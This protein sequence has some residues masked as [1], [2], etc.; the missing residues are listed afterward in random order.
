M[1]NRILLL[2]NIGQF[3]SVSSAAKIP[4]APL[5]LVYSE[6]GRGKT[7]LAAILRSLATG[8]ALPIAERRRLA[9]QN[10][11][12]VV[13]E[14][15]GGPPPAVFEN[16]AWNRT[17]ADLAVFDDVFVDHN[18]CSGLAVETHHG[19]NLHEMVLGATAVGLNKKLLECVN[20]I[21]GHN[22][23]LRDKAGAI[24][25]A[26][27]G[28]F[29]V[30]DFCALPAR[31]DIDQA[32]QEAERALAAA[33]EQHA[34]R[35]TSPF[36]LLNL[37]EFDLIAI[38]RVL[39]QDLPALEVATL[40]QVQEHLSRLG[41]GGEE[42]VADGVQRMS[43][44]QAGTVAIACPFCAQDLKGSPVIQH[45]REYFSHEYAALKRTVSETLG[46]VNREHGEDMAP[47]FERA[48][49]VAIERRQFWSRFCE[50]AEFA[51]D[52][53][54]I[55]RDWRSAREAVVAQLTA[56]QAAP[57]ECMVLSGNTQALV[58]AYEAHRKTVTAVN[59]H[60]LE[61]NQAIGVA[62]E[63]AAAADL[64]VLS[65]DIVRLKAMKARHVPET[66][67]LCDDYLREREAKV[68]TE[69]E[70]EKAKVALEQHRAAVFPG[71]QAAINL[72]LAKFNAGFRLD[73]MWYAD[74]RGGPTCRYNALINNTPVAIGPADPA[75][76]E[77]AFRNTLSSGDR[78][79]LALAFFFASLDQDASL[80]SKVV[81]ID[82][83]ICSL[84]NNR[85]WA[86]VQE[87]RR[88][89][90]RTAQVIVLS[91]N[92]PFLCRL[93]EWADSKRRAALEMVRED[94]G[95]T[96]REWN[97]AEDYITEHDRRHAMLRSYSAEGKGDMRE[98]A[99]SIRPHLEAFLRVACPGQFEPECR[100]GNF[101]DRCEQRVGTAQQIFD[102]LSIR[103]LKDLNEYASRYHHQ[104]SETEP[105]N[106]GELRGFVG[107]ALSFCRK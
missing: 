10:P 73:S 20:R 93:S 94:A 22:H 35:T 96:L 34:I 76:G 57:L 64:A 75:S 30:D 83:P 106:D 91:H 79:T 54:V 6:N 1:I 3:D 72:Y 40:K 102:G 44:W 65:D 99:R 90:E 26:D 7:T 105:I 4:L 8:N 78:H 70:R 46:A 84:D 2:R 37:P 51:V 38:E 92:K 15:G 85:T 18:V 21:E 77:P 88:L 101:I 52:T 98:V 28:P 25:T 23:N 39:Q 97:I 48:V 69:A 33:K 55:V 9:A 59:R 5:T 81:V 49:R 11:P 47:G 12:H 43:Q 42:W 29:P 67:A 104:G 95:S 27:R 41:R 61:A 19:Q 13:I 56:K 24:P 89:A 62:K 71:Y 63:R 53:A 66:S 16:G 31:L 58:T 17:L 100:L 86:T 74:T 60:L 80:A 32:I 87:I 50:I 14:C 36:E 107:R 68:D 45:Y 103:E 82:D